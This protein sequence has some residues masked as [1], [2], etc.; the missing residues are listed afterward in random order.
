VISVLTCTAR[1]QYLAQ[2]IASIDRAGGAEYAGPKIVHV[3]GPA[4]GI[5]PFPGWQVQALSF[6]RSGARR[7]MLD[8]MGRAAA[9]A[10]ELLLYFEDDVVLC[11]GAIPAMLEIGVPE[12]LGFVS[13]CD[14]LWHP[15]P[16][17]ELGVFPGCPRNAPVA[18]GGFVGCQALALPARTI[19]SLIMRTPP[20]WLDRNNCDSTIGTSSE[21]YGVIDSLADHVGMES[22]IM[23]RSYGR[24][25][26]VRGWRGED[27][28]AATLPRTFRIPSPEEIGER[29]HFHAGVLHET[30]RACAA[31]MPNHVVWAPGAGD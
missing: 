30:R 16:P 29:C 14:L 4:D 13:Y 26:T 24:L 2:T 3:D 17:L 11:K 8:I 20:A 28:D 6:A 22:A 21:Y 15:I 5:G 12:P 1:G 19:A 7:S 9:A 10:V 23:G 31:A 18:D 25:R 27:F